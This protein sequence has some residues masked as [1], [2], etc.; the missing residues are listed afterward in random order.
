MVLTEHELNVDR[1][2]T[3]FVD[4]YLHSNKLTTLDNKT[5]NESVVRATDLSLVDVRHQDINFIEL[6]APVASDITEFKEFSLFSVAT[7]YF[8]Q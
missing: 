8:S 5:R 2:Q 6:K 7:H 1:N 3:L 4:G